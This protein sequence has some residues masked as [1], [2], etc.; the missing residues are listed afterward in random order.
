MKKGIGVYIRTARERLDITQAQ[1]AKKVGLSASYFGMLER[2]FPVHLSDDLINRMVKKL[3][4]SRAISKHQAE[5]NAASTK[6]FAAY[7]AAYAK[8]AARSTSKRAS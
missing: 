7:H 8:R 1:A 5:H 4:V 6:R 2:S 3:G